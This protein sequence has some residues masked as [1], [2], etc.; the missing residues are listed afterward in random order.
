MDP[1]S[2]TREVVEP[3]STP[4]QEALRLIVEVFEE[5]YRAAASLR[6]NAS[7]YSLTELRTELEG[8]EERMLTEIAR[9]C[10]QHEIPQPLVPAVPL[11]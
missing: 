3:D 1:L 7:H 5:G 6:E 2:P 10:T 4:T 9:I 11:N 8:I